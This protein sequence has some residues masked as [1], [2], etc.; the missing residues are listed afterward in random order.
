MVVAPSLEPQQI[1]SPV[2]IA[3]E[4]D[5]LR[6]GGPADELIPVRKIIGTNAEQ[7]TGVPDQARQDQ[8]MSPTAISRELDQP[9]YPDEEEWKKDEMVPDDPVEAGLTAKHDKNDDNWKPHDPEREGRTA[10]VKEETTMEAASMSNVPNGS[11][12]ASVRNGLYQHP[13]ARAA[14][15]SD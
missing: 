13:H 12:R 11:F 6:T 3:S 2:K 8:E 15:H 1:L 5:F 9:S 4:E 10:K 7:S 14:R